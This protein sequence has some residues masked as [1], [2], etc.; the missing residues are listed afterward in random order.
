MGEQR[1]SGE[2]NMWKM[3]EGFAETK[4]RLQDTP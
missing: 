2:I 3:N 4:N 1:M